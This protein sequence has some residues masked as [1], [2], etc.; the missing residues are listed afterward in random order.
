MLVLLVLLAPATRRRWEL[1]DR[2]PCCMPG[3]PEPD[4]DSRSRGARWTPGLVGPGRPAAAPD[5]VCGPG[6]PLCLPSPVPDAGAHGVDAE[7]GP[8]S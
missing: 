5:A 3:L 4:G 7:K 8:R 2:H 1:K 6:G